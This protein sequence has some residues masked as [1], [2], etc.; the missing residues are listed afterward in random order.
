MKAFKVISIVLATVF[1]FS[2]VGLC[3]AAC[4][5]DD[6]TQHCVSCCSVGCHTAILSSSLVSITPSPFTS[7]VQSDAMLR[8]GLFLSGIEYPPN[9]II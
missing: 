8:Q 1:L 5:A 2:A 6:D 7:F 4:S 3:D 9:S